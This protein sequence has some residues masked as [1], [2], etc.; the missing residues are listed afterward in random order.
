M[1][2]SGEGETMTWAAVTSV[3][4]PDCDHP[5]P[6]TSCHQPMMQSARHAG[7]AAEQEVPVEKQ[8][9]L[10]LHRNLSKCRPFVRQRRGEGK[11]RMENRVT[12]QKRLFLIPS[13]V[14]TSLCFPD[15]RERAANP[16]PGKHE[17]IFVTCLLTRRA[18]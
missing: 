1:R 17:L 18:V 13:G 2:G 9:H 7:E 3:S 12:R 14:Q 5:L 6:L 10:K 15:W 8:A 11:I 16:S 4:H